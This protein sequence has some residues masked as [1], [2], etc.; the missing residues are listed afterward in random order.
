MNVDHIIPGVVG[1]GVV[2]VGVGSVSERTNIVTVTKHF[3]R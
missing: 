3:N 2:G 1:A